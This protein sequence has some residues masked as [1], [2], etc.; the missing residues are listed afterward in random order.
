[1]LDFLKILIQNI[2]IV[3]EVFKNNLLSDV[4]VHQKANKHFRKKP[5]EFNQA[6]FIKEYKGVYFCFYLRTIDSDEVFTKLEILFKPHYYFNDNL[7]NA[8]DFSVQNCIDVLNEFKTLFKL[9]AN[10]MKIVNIEYGINA[11]SPICCKNLILH[12]IYHE[13]NQFLNMSGLKYAKISYREKPNGTDNKYKQI[14]FYNK[15]VQYPQYINIDTFRF[16]VKSK[17]SPFIKKQ[18]INTLSDLLHHKTYEKLSESILTEFSK[19]LIVDAENEMQN[20]TSKEQTKLT[21]YLNTIK[22]DKAIQGSKNLFNNDKIKYFA[23]LDK[24]GNNVH[25]ILKDIIKNKLRKLLKQCANLT[26]IKKVNSCAVLT[27]N[28]MQ[29]GTQLNN[30][31]CIVTR[32][33][34]SMQKKGS[35]L[36]STNQIRKLYKT[37]RKIFDEVKN[38]YLS[39]KWINADLETQFFEIYHNIR[40]AKSNREIKQKKLYPVHQQRLFSINL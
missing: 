26:P 20:L 5:N 22:W 37:D 9:S 39:K 35:S 1:M 18:G 12:S 33:D 28:I 8:N 16:E 32:L 15:G 11:V 38:K 31:R 13:K 23:L 40:N 17:T 10:E 3:D 36:L 25:N 7:H 29:N 14:K 21:Q 34:I 6:K 24:T 4:S 30:G 2:D 27:T 19:V